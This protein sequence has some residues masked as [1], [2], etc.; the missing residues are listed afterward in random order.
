MK[1][2]RE[3]RTVLIT[4][5]DFGALVNLRTAIDS[6]ML[7]ALNELSPGTLLLCR[8]H[9]R[10]PY[11]PKRRVL[12]GGRLVPALFQLLRHA[13]SSFPGRELAESLFD[14]AAAMKLPRQPALAVNMC[15]VSRRSTRRA[16]RLGGVVIG[17][18]SMAYEGYVTERI[19]GKPFRPRPR[20]E[21]SLRAYD[22][23]LA[24]SEFVKRTH[25]A[26]GFPEERIHVVPRGVD[27][28]R[29]SPGRKRDRRFRILCVA[30]I[31][32]LKGIEYLLEA[33]RLLDLRDA[34]LVIVGIVYREARGLLRRHLRGLRNV[35][36][37]GHTDPLPHYRDCSLLVHP[38]LT[39]GSA[40]VIMEAMACAKPVICTENSGAHFAHG[41]EGYIVPIR[42]AGALAQRINEL[43]EDQRKAARMGRA[44]R[45][46]VERE[47]TL[48]H[49]RKE[50]VKTLK[51]ISES[52]GVRA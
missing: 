39:E 7:D 24:N 21:E 6:C 29:F 22:Y 3:P 8:D 1:P 18:L 48:E 2:E 40:R 13:F 45:R 51:R 30:D 17:D 34:E 52:G 14:A 26:Y 38:S 46:L 23:Y 19:E 33:W 50:L 44:G 42:D 41:R 28:V 12:P 25:V 11:E 35:R 43:R 31:T 32:L 47:L 5:A 36:L 20:M 27:H 37:V 9:R 10:F 4:Y 49:Y 16:Q 15:L